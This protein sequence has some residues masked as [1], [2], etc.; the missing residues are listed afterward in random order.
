[1]ARFGS[2]VIVFAKSNEILGK[3]DRDAAAIVKKQLEADGVTFLTNVDYHS[4]SNGGPDGHEI[5]VQLQK[6]GTRV[7]Y[8]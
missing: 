7:S 6:P 1:M 4:I 2:K 8:P 3:E 5:H